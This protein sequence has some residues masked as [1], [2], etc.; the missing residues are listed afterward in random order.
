[1]IG[2]VILAGG[3]GNRIGGDKPLIDF[4]GKKLIHYVIEAASSVSDE[5]I[6]VVDEDEEKK[7]K[8]IVPE[9]VEVIVDQISGG[10]PLIGLYSGLR[11]IRSEYAVALPCDSPFLN[12][13]VL[14]FL[15]CKARGVDAVIPQWPNG[16]IEPLHSIY[17]VSAALKCSEEALGEGKSRIHDMIDRLEKT[18]FVS[19][20]SI[21]K[22]DPE[23]LTFFNINSLED[24]EK[25]ET[26]IK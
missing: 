26:I 6:V 19:I 21:R 11:Q 5:I 2:A 12:L 1:M 18:I 14:R 15:L 13:E 10:G 8:T 17:K 25:A 3:A 4:K 7:F 22:F 20:E 24:L 23:L 16:Y 9:D